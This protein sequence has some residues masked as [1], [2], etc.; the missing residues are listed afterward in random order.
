MHLS[1]NRSF[2]SLSLAVV[3]GLMEASL[4]VSAQSDLQTPPVKSNRSDVTQAIRA[5]LDFPSA[6]QSVT[7][8]S[9]SA[10]LIAPGDEINVMV[11][12]AP[13]LSSDSRV[14]PDGSISFPLIGHVRVA[15]LTSSGAEEAIKAQLLRDNIVND[16][17]VSVNVKEYGSGG[18]SVA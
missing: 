8:P 18:V 13:D 10:P 1:R 15:G 11:Y 17:Q 16:P 14:S 4:P 12:D 2:A 3:L 6:K 9:S 7:Q 5:P